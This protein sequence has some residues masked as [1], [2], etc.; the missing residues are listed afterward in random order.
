MG[1]ALGYTRRAAPWPPRRTCVETRAPPAAA[2]AGSA[3]SARPTP[4]ILPARS[5]TT[6]QI[7]PHVRTYPGWAA[8]C[9][10]RAGLPPVHLA[11]G[12]VAIFVWLSWQAKRQQRP[13][14]SATY[15][16]TPSHLP[17]GEVRRVDARSARGE[18]GGGGAGVDGKIM[19]LVLAPYGTAGPGRTTVWWNCEVER[20]GAN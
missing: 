19:L 10:Q 16:K 1:A 2:A 6:G 8:R 9:G 4:A 17:P 20:Y 14:G 5:R 15:R 13:T 7:V 11:G 18:V 3:Q 12:E